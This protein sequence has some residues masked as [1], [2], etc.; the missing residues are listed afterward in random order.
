MHKPGL[1]RTQGRIKTQ[2]SI[3]KMHKPGFEHTRPQSNENSTIKFRSMHEPRI[4][5]MH[6]RDNGAHTQHGQRTHGKVNA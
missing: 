1:E 3:H 4:E 5:L 6:A 2:N